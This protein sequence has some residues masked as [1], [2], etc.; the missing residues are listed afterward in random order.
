MKIPRGLYK[1]FKPSSYKLA[2]NDGVST[3]YITGHKTGRPSHRI[4]LHQKNLKIL[5]AEI[6]KLNKDGLVHLDVERINH[7]ATFEEVRLHTKEMIYPGTYRL[8]INY[9]GS[10]D[11]YPNLLD[12]CSLPCI[13]EP[14]AWL[15]AKV[16]FK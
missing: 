16:D 8:K 9:S 4:T 11:I 1:D 12:R 5:Q 15:N 2:A 6:F 7:L 13:D 10:Q 14:E 3:V